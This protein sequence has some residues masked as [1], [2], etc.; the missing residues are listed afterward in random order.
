MSAHGRELPLEGGA[1]RLRRGGFPLAGIRHAPDTAIVWSLASH[2][3]AQPV[4]VHPF[5]IDGRAA[6]NLV[7]SICMAGCGLSRLRP[8]CGVREM[9]AASRRPRRRVGHGGTGVLARPCA[10]QGRYHTDCG[11][12]QAIAPRCRDCSVTTEWI[13]LL[14]RHWESIRGGAPM[15]RRVAST[16]APPSA[17][18]ANAIERCSRMALQTDSTISLTVPIARLGS[19]S[20]ADCI[21]LICRCDSGRSKVPTVDGVWIYAQGRNAWRK[22]GSLPAEYAKPSRLIHRF[23]AAKHLSAPR[24]RSAPVP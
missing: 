23:S 3:L 12:H 8:R 9:S 2:L 16:N 17:S 13:R 7:Y 15:H 19:S 11:A 21:L 4:A 5:A 22:G 20:T 18:S 24:C 14:W 1:G 10:C 6:V